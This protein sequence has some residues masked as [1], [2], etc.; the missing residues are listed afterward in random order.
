MNDK[1]SENMTCPVESRLVNRRRSTSRH[2]FVVFV[3]VVV[4]AAQSAGLIPNGRNSLDVY[5]DGDIQ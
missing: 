5:L 3:F 1:Y 2:F 4:S